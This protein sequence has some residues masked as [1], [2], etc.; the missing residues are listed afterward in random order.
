M[1][2]IEKFAQ[3]TTNFPIITVESYITIMDNY[4]NN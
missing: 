4:L 3:K 1:K 2:F